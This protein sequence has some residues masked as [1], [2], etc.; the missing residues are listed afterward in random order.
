MLVRKLVYNLSR[1]FD[2]FFSIFNNLLYI[3]ASLGFL[4]IILPS[5]FFSQLFVNS[6]S[7]IFLSR[8]FF[9]GFF[10]HLSYHL[11][12]LFFFSYIKFK[13]KGLGHRVRRIGKNFYKF[14]FFSTSFYYFYVPYGL[15]FRFKKKRILMI[16]RDLAK[17]KHTLAQLLLLKQVTV[18]RKRGMLLF[19]HILL[20]KE[21]KRRI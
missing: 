12:H 15:I 3:K 21:G 4:V 1:E 2:F 17:L 11:K 13:I 19:K 10:S 8:V 16:S 5:Y 6:I 14:F 9:R 7:F 18:Y 20:R